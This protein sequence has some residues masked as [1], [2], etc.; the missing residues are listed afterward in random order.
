MAVTF[1]SS[2]KGIQT[3]TVV[4][5][6][7]FTIA[8]NACLIVGVGTNSDVSISACAVNG[9][10][11]TQ[12]GTVLNDAG[13]IRTNLFGLT[14]APSGVVSISANMVGGVASI[15][16]IMGA[17]Y[18]GASPT[19]CFGNVIVGTAG[20]VATFALSLS[21][22]TTDRVVMFAGGANAFTATNSTTRQFDTAHDAFRMADTAGPA[23]SISLSASCVVA[24]QNLTFMGINIINSDGT[25]RFKMS[26]GVGT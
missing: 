26:L 8:A 24:S 20:A 10:L 12:L 18:L 2:A 4:G 19:N 11:L 1:D 7:T 5:V 14:A 21:T 9:T 22:S 13:T 17:S 6:C 23:S 25:P 15:I 16:M 3:S